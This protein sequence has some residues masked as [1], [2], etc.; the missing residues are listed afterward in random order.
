MWSA[1]P[2]KI[3]ALEVTRTDAPAESFALA[4]DGTDWK[5]TGPFTAPVKFL[6]AQ[7][8]LTALGALTAVKYQALSSAG[9]SEYGFDK[10]LLKVKLTY[11]EKKPAAGAPANGDEQ[12]VTKTV[13]VG[14]VAPD[15]F[16]RYAKLDAPDAPVFVVPAGFVAAAE[17]PPLELL[18]RSLLLLNHI[19]EEIKWCGA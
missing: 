5:L 7:P 15:G 14:G 6:D 1:P 4:R 2:E 8:M 9:S 13:V 3:T 19:P 12:P 11:P 17:T 16:N 10:P 18:D